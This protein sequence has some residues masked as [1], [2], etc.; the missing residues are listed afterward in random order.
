MCK[1]YK[2]SLNSKNFSYLWRF[3]KEKDKN[4]QKL[5]DIL[6]FLPIVFVPKESGLRQPIHTSQLSSYYIKVLKEYNLKTRK[7]YK[8]HKYRGDES[9]SF[10]EMLLRIRNIN[11]N[12]N[13]FSRCII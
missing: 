9:L 7:K 4:I 5:A 8:S 10:F 13:F 3:R 2:I 11:K 1:K 6:K 12:D